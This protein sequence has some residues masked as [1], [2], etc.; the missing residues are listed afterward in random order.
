MAEASSLVHSA[1]GR[2]AVARSRRGGRW[3]GRVHRRIRAGGLLAGRRPSRGQWRETNV[4]FEGPTVQRL[5]AAFAS[6][7]AEATGELLTGDMF[8]PPELV[9]GHRDMQSRA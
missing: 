7:W 2:A 5:Q 9:R 4:R 6:A 8:F 3:P 1:Q